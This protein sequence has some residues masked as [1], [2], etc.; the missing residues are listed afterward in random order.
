MPRKRRIVKVRTQLEISAGLWAWL[1]DEPVS[2]DDHEANWEVLMLEGGHM[3]AHGGEDKLRDLWKGVREDVLARWAVDHPGT[4]P[5]LWW[6]LEAPR[7][8]LGTW[9][10]CFFD[11]KLQEPRKRLGGTGKAPWDA[12]LAYV[13]SFRCGV[14]SY[15]DSFSE[16][17]PPVFESQAAYLK[18]QGLLTA[19]EKR[20]LK[21]SDYRPEVLFAD[22]VVISN[23]TAEYR[24][25]RAADKGEKP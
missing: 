22:E 5:S 16:E 17:D 8:A 21:P 18:R 6:E 24:K 9:P 12:G 23:F 19:A 2:K 14:P 11:G 4:R 3:N 20:K 1:N 15:W 7:Q 25:L 10:G 13:P